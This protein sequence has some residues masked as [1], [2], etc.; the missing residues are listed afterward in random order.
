MRQKHT[1]IFV[2][3]FLYKDIKETV[4]PKVKKKKK[5]QLFSAHLHTDGKSGKTKHFW[6]L[7]AKRCC[8]ILLNNWRR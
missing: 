3:L 6:G 4:Q 7:T 2:E 1:H 8:S 5:N